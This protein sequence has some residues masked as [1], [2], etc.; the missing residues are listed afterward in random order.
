VDKT[1]K[2]NI[3]YFLIKNMSFALSSLSTKTGGS[4]SSVA[5]SSNGT[6]GI[7]GSFGAGIFYTNNSG[8]TCIQSTLS[9]GTTDKIPWFI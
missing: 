8:S 5:L 3:F 4:F 7:A 1:L 2:N 6:K 9:D